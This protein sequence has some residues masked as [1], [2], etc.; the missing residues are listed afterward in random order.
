[1]FYNSTRLNQKPI[2]GSNEAAFLVTFNS[3]Q[4]IFGSAA[5]LLE[6]I[7]FLRRRHLHLSVS[8][9]LTLNLAVA[10]LVS[11]TTYLPWRTYLLHIRRATRDY[12]YY[13]SLFVFC[14]FNTG[15]AIVLM[16]VDRFVAIIRPLRYHSLAT[17]K[18]VWFGVSLSW[19]IAF[20][21]STGHYLSYK[22][23]LLNIHADYEF[24]LSCLSIGHMFLM[25]II[26]IVILRAAKKQVKAVLLLQTNFLTPDSDSSNSLFIWNYRK[27]AYTTF[28]IVCLFY[29]TFLPYSVYRIV[30]TFDHT[31]TKTSKRITWR[32][33]MSFSFLN[34]CL[35]PFIYF[36]SMKRFRSKLKHGL[37]NIY[38]K[39][40]AC[41]NETSHV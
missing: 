37:L 34:S 31:I 11:L 35:N 29:A 28:S 14:I 36:I 30:T 26:Y 23:V 33:L 39:N 2:L 25:S 22:K 4:I 5:N 32:W 1:M 13:T 38:T 18:V 40:V 15:N 27:S 8:D 17:G 19:S 12:Q 9:K 41:K 10:D 16:S 7:F 3:L 24:F 21:L 6:I 20:T